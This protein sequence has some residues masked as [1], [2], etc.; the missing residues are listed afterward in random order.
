MINLCCAFG[1]RSSEYEVS[2]QS[3]YNVIA[4]VDP[5]K[6]RVI[7]LGITKQGVWYVYKG[8]LEKIRDGSWVLDTE[9]LLPCHLSQNYQD[10]NLYVDG[11]KVPVDVF[12]PVMHGE[13]CEDGILQGALS[14]CGIPFVG[15][16][17]SASAAAMDKNFTKQIVKEKGIPQANSI[18]VFRGD[19]RE[20]LYAVTEQVTK[21]FSFPVFVKPAN[22][23]SSVGVT[24]VKEKSELEGALLLAAEYDEK[25]LIEE[26][27]SG[28]EFEV[29]VL[30]N[31]NP[32]AS[33]VGE[34]VVG[35]EFYDYESKYI[36]DTAS[37][38]VPARLSEAVSQK[39]R[40]YAVEVFKALGC[41]GLARVDFFVDKDRIVFNEINTLPGFTPISMYPKLQIYG[42][43]TYGQL[44]DRLIEL[45]LEEA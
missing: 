37:Y 1:G 8:D 7:K 33:C 39:V 13:N 4:N 17:C 11:E 19:V 45:A 3:A 31:Q 14:L 35:S 29:A 16:G 10:K 28:G 26:Y 27:I 32:S 30:G 12:F 20:N 21:N 6:Y 36:D 5:E 44:I 22:A 38:Y 40:D 9:N 42:G 15:S 24:K 25:I 2:L 18:C 41:R 23:G 43:L 34:I